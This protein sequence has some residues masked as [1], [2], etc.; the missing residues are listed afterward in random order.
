MDNHYHLL[1]ETRSG[2]L[3]PTIGLV[4]SAFPSPE[5]REIVPIGASVVRQFRPAR[6]ACCCSSV[7]A[8]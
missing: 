7:N 1:I 4:A 6:A 2:K 8:T 5:S 3:T